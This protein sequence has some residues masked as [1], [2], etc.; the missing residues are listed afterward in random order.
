MANKKEV[1]EYMKLPY[2][3][4]IIP[5][6]DGTYSVVVEEF[7]GCMSNGKTPEEALEM[8]KDAMEVWLES[9][10]DMGLEIPL[11]YNSEKDE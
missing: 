9:S 1:Q 11:P 2:T 4:K 8:I 3:I 5:E 6:E 7:S 10:I